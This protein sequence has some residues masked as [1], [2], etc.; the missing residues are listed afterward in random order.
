MPAVAQEPALIDVTWTVPN[1]PGN[2]NFTQVN[3]SGLPGP[4]TTPPPVLTFPV[5]PG[6]FTAQEPASP[7]VD[8]NF[9]YPSPSVTLPSPPTLL[10]LDPVNFN[11]FV[12]PQFN[13]NVPEIEIAVPNVI[14]FIEPALFTRIRRG[15]ISEREA[16]RIVAILDKARGEI[17]RDAGED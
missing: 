8:L 5:Q 15:G 3:T 12:I 14:P 6:A 7:S 9:T 16:S 13:V 2:P 4:F 10:S 11:P 17:E 1:A